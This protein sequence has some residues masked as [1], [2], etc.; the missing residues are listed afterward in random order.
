[1]KAFQIWDSS[2]WAGWSWVWLRL[3]RRK[4]RFFSHSPKT[5]FLKWLQSLMNNKKMQTLLILFTISLITLFLCAQFLS[6]H[7]EDSALLPLSFGNAHYVFQLLLIWKHNF[8]IFLHTLRLKKLLNTPQL[9]RCHI[10]KSMSNIDLYF[11][12]AES[13]KTAAQ[14]SSNYVCISGIHYHC[15]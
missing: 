11:T 6:S 9:H 10:K 8:D 13:L 1:M 7:L 12:S 14:Y 5:F 3:R 2:T 4:P 15:L